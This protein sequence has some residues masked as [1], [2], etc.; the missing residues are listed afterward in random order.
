MI[1]KN[2]LSPR[3]KLI[4]RDELYFRDGTRCHQCHIEEYNFRNIWGDNFYGGIKRGGV[5]EIDRK[6]NDREY[7]RE[8]CILACAICNMAKS[9]KFSHDEFQKIGTVIEEIW[10]Q[11]SKT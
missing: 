2:N 3:D 10:R 7:S 6:D 11:K 8:N 5:L 9:D 1:K 4:L